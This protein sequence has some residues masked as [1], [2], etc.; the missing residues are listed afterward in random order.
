MGGLPR[1]RARLERASLLVRV[2]TAFAGML[3]G[4]PN[5]ARE[6]RNQTRT[7]FTT[8]FAR[9]Y[10]AVEFLFDKSEGKGSYLLTSE[11]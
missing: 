4:A 9:G 2:P 3:E 1:R 10:R 6:W 5:L 11:D 7:I 8:F